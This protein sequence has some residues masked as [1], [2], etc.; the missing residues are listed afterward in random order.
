MLPAR[1]FTLYTALARTIPGI[2]VGG[3]GSLYTVSNGEMF[4][5]ITKKGEMALRLSKADRTKF[6]AKY[7]TKIFKRH[8]VVSKEYVEVPVSLLERTDELAPYF[9]LAH[10]YVTSL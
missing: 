3:K 4:S 8:G 7:K 9:L 6:I 1:A 2:E 10:T 5:F